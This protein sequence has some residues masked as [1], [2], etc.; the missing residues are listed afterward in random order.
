MS[1]ERDRRRSRIPRAGM[2]II[3]VAREPM[4]QLRRQAPRRALWLFVWLKVLRPIGVAGLWLLAV[5]YAWLRLFGTP[6]ELPLWQQGTLYAGA[7]LAIVLAMLVLVRLRHREARGDAAS[8]FP[9]S[10][11]D[12]LSTLTNVPVDELE[13]WQQAQRLVVHHDD[14][15]KVQGAQARR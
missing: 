14:D 8:G 13:Q 10:T 5:R 6:D 12:E 4:E 3:D 15:G 11:T 2:P 7:L 9:P 1:T